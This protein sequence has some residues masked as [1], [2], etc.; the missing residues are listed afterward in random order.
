MKQ[1]RRIANT[2]GIYS[3]WF[4]WIIAIGSLAIIPI[5]SLYIPKSLLPIIIFL[6]EIFLY[7]KIRHNAYSK[8]SSCLRLLHI[9]M[10]SLFWSLIIILI[11]TIYDYLNLTKIELSGNH[12]NNSVPFIPILILAPVTFIVTL[13]NLLKGYTSNICRDC[14]ARHGSIAERGFLGKLFS[15]EGVFLSQML[16]MLS[17]SLTVLCWGYYL[18]FYINTNINDIDRFMFVWLQFVV[19]IVN[20][21]YLGI[22]YY[23]LWLYY[24]QD[25]E[26]Q[27]LRY[28]SSSL[29]RFII[30]SGDYI[31]L[32]TPDIKSDNITS[33]E[34]LIDT[35]A[36][37]FLQY[38]KNIV[39]NDAI[40]YFRALSGIANAE[41]KFL[42]KNTNFNTECNIFHYAYYVEDKETIEKSRL[43]GEWYN[44]PQIKTLVHKN[45]L[46]HLFI[47]E[48]KRIY[49]IAMT[50]KT[51]DRTGRRLYNIK[52]YKPT[53][54]LRDLKD[55]DV[56]YNDIAWLF[57]SANNQDCPFF[58]T[59]K[60]WNKYICGISFV[61]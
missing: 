4:N 55:W 23:S 60:L 31:F 20:I 44:L 22:K 38:K 30:I 40:E 50:W 58:K 16:L 26:G 15:Q 9:A 2:V 25:I 29:V 11:I 36:R 7:L 17:F 10:V 13:Y 1:E 3:L 49:T 28:N 52:N 21:I 33:D 35:P 19:Y 46:S 61:K 37:L 56:D 12:V 27:S 42:Y 32:K 39:D 5:V 8:M 59:R 45:K 43:D 24:Q 53:F 54:R 34:S 41:I 51:F 47:S 48:L 18:I 57:V 14:Y 6:L